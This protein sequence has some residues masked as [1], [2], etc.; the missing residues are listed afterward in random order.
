MF[1]LSPSAAERW[2]NCPGSTSIISKLPPLHSTQAAEEGTL[3]HTFAAAY[4]YSALS[5]VY[6][7]ASANGAP[8][9]PE[10]ALA[11]DEIINGAQ[12]YADSI[13]S[14]ISEVSKGV[15]ISFGIEDEC[16]LYLND[17]DDGYNDKLFKGRVDF[18][19]R[20]S[21][22]VLI[23]ADYKFGE[24]F[25]PAAKNKQMLC[26]YACLRCGFEKKCVL[27]IIQPN[28]TGNDFANGWGSTWAEYD[29]TTR[30]FK[31][32]IISPL[33][34]SALAAAK[35]DDRTN[36]KCGDWCK[37]CP[38]RSV[39]RARIGER[40]LLAAIAAGESQ[41]QN[42]ATNEQIAV[43]LDALKEI[44]TA[45]DDLARIAKM[46][47]QNDEVVPGWRIQYR[48]KAAWARALTE[49]GSAEE[50][51]ERIADAIGDEVQ[52]ADIIK[53]LLDVQLVTPAKLKKAIP[54]NLVERA[55]EEATTAALVKG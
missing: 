1:T 35:A 26:Y 10:Q 42:D 5:L 4:L 43:W 44:D 24:H 40:L 47:I 39:C 38:A 34:E 29:T 25:V 50:Q 37:Y 28:T 6:P 16:D 46:R 7:D 53:L 49:C 36:R 3:A 52:K 31:E 30:E 27:G 12:V 23:I 19:A 18:W 2:S 45:R 9:Q 51:A 8:E 41:M 15:V 33:V 13:I 55:T 20:T 22:G 17:L 54:A 11:T 21:D 14:K 48:K 32:E